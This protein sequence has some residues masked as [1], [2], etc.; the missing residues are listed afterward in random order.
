MSSPAERYAESN[1]I[2]VDAYAWYERLD[3][4]EIV[5]LFEGTPEHADAVARWE[6]DER[7][8]IVIRAAE[9]DR[10]QGWET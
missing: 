1:R 8:D 2:A 7:D 9:A 6:Q 5:A 4:D 10:E 3:V